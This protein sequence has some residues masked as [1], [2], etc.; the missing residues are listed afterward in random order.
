MRNK[1]FWLIFDILLLLVTGLGVFFR[2]YNMNW[3]SGALLHPD[4]YGLTNTL[5]QLEM[6]SNISD[7]FNI[8][9][10]WSSD[11]ISI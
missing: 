7:Y 1:K 8:C 2:F 11:T 5:T 3:D 9:S 6:P 4:E 10:I